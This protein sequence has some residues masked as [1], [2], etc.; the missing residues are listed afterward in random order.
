MCRRS[1]VSPLLVALAALGSAQ[2]QSAPLVTVRQTGPAD[3]VGGD[4]RALAAAIERLKASGGTIVLGPGR[5]VMRRSVRLRKN[6]VL[7]GESG[8]VIV[9]R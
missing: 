3:V 7:R 9:S 1:L 2:E 8:L 6:L 4:D 5:Y